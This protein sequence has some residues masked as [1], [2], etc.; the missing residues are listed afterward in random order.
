MQLNM[1]SAEYPN[2]KYCFSKL[3]PAL[4]G[5]A[6]CNSNLIHGYRIAQDMYLITIPA[7]E[8]GV[9]MAGIIL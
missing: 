1:L 7:I 4:H 6:R 3:T 2:S 9:A 8:T 5:H